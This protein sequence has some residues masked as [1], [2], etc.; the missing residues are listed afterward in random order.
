MG[1][2]F[3]I[4]SGRPLYT[5]TTMFSEL[6]DQMSFIGDNGGVISYR[7]EIIFTSLIERNKLVD[8]ISFT[9]DQSDVIAILCGLDSAYISRT[10]EKY[11]DFLR[12]FYSQITTVDSLRAVE[13]PADKFTAYFP[14]HNSK[15]SYEEIFEPQF[16][17]N[18]SVTVGDTIW[19]DIMNRGV[20]KGHA[21][22]TLGERLGIGS[23]QM[24][25]F[26]DTYND[27]QMLQ[28]VKFSYIVANAD[29]DMRQYANFVAP[30]NQEYGV[31]KVLDE[32][33]AAK[34][35]TI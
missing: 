20:D 25:A 7:G 24:M 16:G 34:N 14:N 13:S 17:D 2:D 5:L 28:A 12:T 9:E 11:V 31:I 30:S 23:E 33:I 8:L 15:S 26:G 22:R 32:L 3:V 27:A 21:M 10:F 35:S 18:L 1:V 4:A 29:P 6:K 19:I